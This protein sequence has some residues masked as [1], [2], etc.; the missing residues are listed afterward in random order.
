MPVPKPRLSQYQL[1]VRKWEGG[2]GS[3]LCGHARKVCHVRGTLP[4][5]VLFVGEA[6]G[7]AEDVLGRPFCGPA[8]HLLDSIVKK[9]LSGVMLGAGAMTDEDISDGE[10]V[11]CAFCNLV[12]CIPRDP[13]T[14]GK[15]GQPDVE[16]IMTCAPRLQE[17]IGM[18][19]PR[20]VVA[21]GALANGWLKPGYKNP[22]QLPRGVAFIEILHPAYILRQNTANQGFLRQQQAIKL[23]SAVEDI[24]QHVPPPPAPPPKLPPPLPLFDDDIPF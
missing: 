7:D 11:R 24:G 12:G 4:C 1:H 8:G 3:A 5:D 23:R 13:D 2:C 18:A 17:I 21:V 14:G 19:R 22:V 16:S 20:L 10:P 9:A 6:P 15:A